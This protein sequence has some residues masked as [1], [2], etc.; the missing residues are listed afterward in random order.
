MDYLSFLLYYYYYYLMIRTCGYITF[1]PL[2]LSEEEGSNSSFPSQENWTI[3]LFIFYFLMKE[4]YHLLQYSRPWNHIT[5]TKVQHLFIC[6]RVTFYSRLW[7]TIISSNSIIN[8]LSVLYF[9]AWWT[10]NDSS[11]WLG[12][13]MNTVS[14]FLI[15]NTRLVLELQ[16]QYLP[17]K[18]ELNDEDAPY[19]IK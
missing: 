3:P 12:N 18:R 16:I 19:F 17:I 13:L 11:I 9:K 15:G 4:Q 2:K 10:L 8:G 7:M 14:F 6:E 1:F 5:G